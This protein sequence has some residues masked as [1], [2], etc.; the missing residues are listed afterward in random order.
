MWC[1]HTGFAT[2]K[3]DT[4]SGRCSTLIFTPLEKSFRAPRFP[5]ARSKGRFASPKADGIGSDYGS[6]ND[7][8]QRLTT[9]FVPVLYLCPLVGKL[10]LLCLNL[11]WNDLNTWVP[12]RFERWFENSSSDA[13]SFRLLTRS[14]F[15]YSLRGLVRSSSYPRSHGRTS[16]NRCAN[17]P[18]RCVTSL[19]N[20]R[21]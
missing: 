7:D 11:A 15:G 1:W 3:H 2:E 20:S 17:H 10:V 6:G 19:T 5:E 9:S 12:N 13:D 14:C 16:G 4:S 8:R 18:C 21:G